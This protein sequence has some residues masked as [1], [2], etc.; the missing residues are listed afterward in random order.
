MKN[1]IQFA[2]PEDVNNEFTATIRYA[3][4]YAA[5]F[6]ILL[7][8][9]GFMV[10]HV[11]VPLLNIPSNANTVIAVVINYASCLFAAVIVLHRF[12]KKH[13][14]LLTKGE[15]SRIR[16]LSVW[17]SLLLLLPVLFVVFTGAPFINN[18]LELLV[19]LVISGLVQWLLTW[20][21]YKSAQ[22]AIVNFSF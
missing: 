2:N 18:L 11:I 8:V 20:L 19:L 1:K 13:G 17:C 15:H 6:L 7:I 3:W 5:L 12:R 21:A 22:K 14:R 16:N 4:L 10:I 9:G